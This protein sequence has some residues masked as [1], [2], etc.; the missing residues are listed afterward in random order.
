MNQAVDL[1][2]LSPEVREIWLTRDEEP[3][4]CAPFIVPESRGH[5]LDRIESIEMAEKILIRAKDFLKSREI[6]CFFRRIVLEETYDEIG[7]HYGITGNRA[8]DIFRRTDIKLR[9]KAFV[10]LLTPTR[11]PKLIFG[12][13]R[14]E[15]PRPIRIRVG[16]WVPPQDR[17][18]HPN[19]LGWVENT[20]S[21]DETAYV[22]PK[23]KVLGFAQVKDY[24][25]IVDD[26]IV[27]DHAVISGDAV[28]GGFATIR[29]RAHIHGTRRDDG[30][31]VCVFKTGPFAAKVRGGIFS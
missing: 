15:R 26:A 28:I 30:S 12:N 10:P 3:E 29:D 7:K 4:S 11:F 18:I 20:A 24:A 19:G 22:G 17:H 31:L 6:D 23:A 27:K 1:A 13:Q 9:S 16:K 25:L 21:V 14:I 8:R 5:E 2:S